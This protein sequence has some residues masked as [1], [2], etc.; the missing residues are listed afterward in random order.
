M[1][2]PSAEEVGCWLSA[3]AVLILFKMII[4]FA[5]AQH[6]WQAELFRRGLMEYDRKTGEMV[7]TEKAGGVRNECNTEKKT[8]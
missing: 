2:M 5:I 7:W 8:I 6:A 4:C 3:T 1:L